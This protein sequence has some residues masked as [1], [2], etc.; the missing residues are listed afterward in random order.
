ML[1]LPIV[2]QGVTLANDRKC[3]LDAEFRARFTAATSLA[4]QRFE[5]FDS[6]RWEGSVMRQPKPW[7]RKQTKSWYVQIDGKQINLGTKKREAWNKYHE[8]MANGV[9]SPPTETIG[10]LL[11]KYLDWCEQSL[12][13]PTCK[14]NRF[15][16][17]RF[18]DYIDPKLAATDVKPLHVQQWIDKQYRGR[19]ATYK[20]IAITAVKA[21]FNW[22]AEQGYIDHSPIARMKK[23]RWTCRE[24]YVPVV[25]WLKVLG[26]ARGQQFKELIIVMFA[27]GARPQ[28]MR[29]FE[30]H[31]YEPELAR[32]VLLR[33]ESKGKKR[34]RV[35]YLDDITREIVERLI[36]SHPQG[37]L[38]RN[39][40]GRP[41]PADALSA[42]FRRLRIKLEMP[43][44]CAYTLRHSYAH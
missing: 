23:P 40:R 29:R 11:D 7:F 33:E 18:R 16:I 14:K 25:D 8:I 1:S 12:A 3:P 31:H 6:L 20:N 15:H 44:L 39:S 19:S 43:K 36:A 22:A 5:L 2:A 30:A 24:F 34:R 26:A 42:R 35:I 10:A 21:A 28:E 27:S 32:I 4:F 38:F 9:S 13:G 37:S 41:W 17:N